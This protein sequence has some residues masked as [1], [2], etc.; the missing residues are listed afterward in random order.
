MLPVLYRSGDALLRRIQASPLLMQRHTHLNL[1]DT[2]SVGTT[3][4]VGDQGTAAPYRPATESGAGQA[5]EDMPSYFH[6]VIA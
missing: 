5:S 4:P 2:A 3:R 1:I 6:R